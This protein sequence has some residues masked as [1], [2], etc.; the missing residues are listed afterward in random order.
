MYHCDGVRRIK[1]EGDWR[2][3]GEGERMKGKGI[4]RVALRVC[5]CVWAYLWG[6]N[7]YIQSQI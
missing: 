3:G 1:E 4:R 6:K 7:D 2:R 5:V